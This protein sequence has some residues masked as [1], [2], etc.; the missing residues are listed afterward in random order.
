M[1][2]IISTY[3]T[4]LNTHRSINS[5]LHG[6]FYQMYPKI[7]LQYPFVLDHPVHDIPVHDIPVHDIPVHDFT[8]EEHKEELTL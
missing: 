5:M 6:I 2:L 3:Y 4:S 7:Q 1:E 8:Y